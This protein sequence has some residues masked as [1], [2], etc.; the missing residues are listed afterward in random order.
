MAR[1][2]SNFYLVFYKNFFLNKK[3][4]GEEKNGC[5]LYLNSVFLS[6]N[7]MF[8]LSTQKAVL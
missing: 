3:Y 1:L 2:T 5:K 7:P 6:T 4:F 8:Y